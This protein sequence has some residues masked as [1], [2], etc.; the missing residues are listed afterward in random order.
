MA[1]SGA[2]I[3]RLSTTGVVAWLMQEVR[4]FA[5]LAADGFLL[6]AR[7]FDAPPPRYDLLIKI[8]R[9]Q[10]R[11]IDNQQ[12]ACRHVVAQFALSDTQRLATATREWRQQAAATDRGLAIGFADDVTLDVDITLPKAPL[13]LLEQAVAARAASETPYAPGEGLAFWSITRSTPQ[14]ALAKIAFVPLRAV[15]PVLEALER[16]GIAPTLAARSGSNGDWS[17]KP[18]WL[19]TRNVPPPS[20]VARVMAWPRYARVA[21][22]AALLIAG[23]GLANLATTALQASALSSS[24]LEAKELAKQA[25]KRDADIAF[26]AARQ[27]DALVKLQIL[28]ELAARLPAGSWFERIDVKD[29]KLEL[30]GFGASAAETL[31]LIAGIPGV[32]SAELMSAVTRDQSRN[33]ER[34]RVSARTGKPAST[35]AVPGASVAPKPGVLP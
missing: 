3:N 28:N 18:V 30:I 4:T 7:R 14:V 20:R 32:G 24:A 34:F 13:R 35:H 31:R 22:M 21:A 6:A 27:R 25:S 19:E 12:P 11:L 10:V 5:D 2:Q 17:A 1:V 8:G 9:Q 33:L 15:M 23:S 16:E 26:L 29:D